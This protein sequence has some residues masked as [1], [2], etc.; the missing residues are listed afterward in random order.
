MN[1]AIAAEMELEDVERSLQ[2]WEQRFASQDFDVGGLG[3]AHN[4][5]DDKCTQKFRTSFS[6]HIRESSP[7]SRP[8][9]KM[10]TGCQ[11]VVPSFL[12]NDAPRAQTWPKFVLAGLHHFAQVSQ[13]LARFAHQQ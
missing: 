5:T 12:S 6:P 7:L 1:F 4:C 13:N 11:T 9:P 10:P 3:E 2:V 8:A